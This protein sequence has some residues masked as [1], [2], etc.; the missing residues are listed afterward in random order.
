MR[1]SDYLREDMICLHLKATG[2]EEAIREL[3]SFIRKAKEISNYEMF[4][5]DVLE[6]EKL[7][8][9]GI[10]EE[11]AIP[12]ARTDAV[13]GFVIAFGKSEKGVEFGSL[14]GKKARLLFL[15][16]TPKT[17]GLDEYLVLLAHLT[18]LLKQQSFRES[19]LKAGSPAEIIDIFRNFEK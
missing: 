12:H 19:L 6:R 16:G 13:S 14:D 17:A 15:M 10:G 8:T 5:K 3:G 4:Y 18:R 7:T 2:K 1:I 9:T 11:V